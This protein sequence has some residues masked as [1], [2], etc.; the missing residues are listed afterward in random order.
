[1]Y[2]IKCMSKRYKSYKSYVTETVS[3]EYS[4]KISDAMCVRNSSA[5][6]VV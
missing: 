5:Q 4:V 2:S 6:K 3:K 1:V